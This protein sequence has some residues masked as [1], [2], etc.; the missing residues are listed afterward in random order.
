MRY[1]D[2]VSFGKKNKGG[3]RPDVHR[4]GE[5]VA[6]GRVD[7]VEGLLVVRVLVD[8]HGQ[9]GAKDLI[10][11]RHGLGILGQDDGWLYEEALRVV[12]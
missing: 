5:R 12:P 6:G 8:V 10:N 4:A 2:M 3:E 1:D 9:D 7:E 11:H